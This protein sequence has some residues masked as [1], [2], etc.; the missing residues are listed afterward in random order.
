MDLLNVRGLTKFFGGLAAVADV[1][2]NLVEGQITSL[3]GPNGAGKTTTINLITGFLP[4]TSGEI[5]FDGRDIGALPA[6]KIVR[7]GLVRTFQV[8]Q[9]TETFTVEEAVL[10]GTHSRLSFGLMSGLF[11]LPKEHA[12]QKT[13]LEMA[14][15]AM[16]FVGLK[17]KKHVV[18]AHLPYGEKRMVELG[19]ALATQPKMLLLDEPAAGLNTAERLRLRQLILDIKASGLTILLIEHDVKMVMGLSD[20][21]VVLNFGEKIAEG[22]PA[23]IQENPKVIEAYLGGGNS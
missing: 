11:R 19:R 17:K 2:F 8:S 14:N 15:K 10:L 5:L 1:D 6:H 3:I 13:G 21:V 16:E 12:Q 20:K 18:C 7:L 9:V 4:R 23:E 22:A